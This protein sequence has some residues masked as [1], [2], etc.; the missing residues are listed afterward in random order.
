MKSVLEALTI[1]FSIALAGYLL[2]SAQLNLDEAHSQDTLKHI[3]KLKSEL[4]KPIAEDVKALNNREPVELFSAQAR[5]SVAVFFSIV[6]VIGIICGLFSSKLASTKGYDRYNWF[7]V[8][9]FFS[10]IGLI[11]SAGLGKKTGQVSSVAK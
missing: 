3:I 9:F 5:M 2:V 10:F 8:G 1:T 7:F 11:A 6:L 4:G